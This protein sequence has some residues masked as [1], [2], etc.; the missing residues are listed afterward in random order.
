MIDHEGVYLIRDIFESVYD[1]FEMIVYFIANNELHG[2]FAF[3]AGQKERFATLRMELVCLFLDVD[4]LLRKL[5]ELGAIVANRAQ[6]RQRFEDK[7]RSLQN[8]IAHL[9]HLW[10]EGSDLKQQDG[11]RRLVHLV[12]RVVEPTY[13]VLDIGSIEWRDERPANRN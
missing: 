3:P 4:D 12:D 11:F 9:P 13:E 6:Q 1:F 8:D 10:F 5:V 7:T 2:V